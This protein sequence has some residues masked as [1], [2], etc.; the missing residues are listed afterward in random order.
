M[1][2]LDQRLDMF[3]CINIMVL[4]GN[5]LVMILM[6]KQ[7]MITEAADDWSWSGYS[8]SLSSDGTRLAVGA[9]YK[10]YTGS[11]TGHVRVHQYN[12]TTWQ[13]IGND[14]DGEAATDWSGYSVS[15]SSDGTRL[16]VGAEENDGT[17]T[18][19]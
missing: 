2:V 19:I 15:L 17:G 12:G 5:K 11:K 18:S 1:E 7:L 13:Q 8:V 9:P 3:V 6:E 4:H 14:I 16:A 10:D